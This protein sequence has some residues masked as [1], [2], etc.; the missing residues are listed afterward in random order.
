MPSVYSS[1]AF[2]AY[3]LFAANTNVGKTIFSTGL[4]RAA[5]L[6]ANNH[7]VF[8]LKPVQTGYPTDSDE[9]HVKTYNSSSIYT[10][11]EYTYPDPV[12][13]HIA[14][15]LPPSDRQVMDKT[16]QHILNCV[17]QSKDKAGAYFF[18]ETAGGIHSP[19][20]SGTSQ[21]DFYRPL[22]MPTVL[23]G[24]SNLGGIS[25]TLTSYE[26]LH[27]RG[28]DVPS[29]LLFN[30]D[31]YKNHEL[32]AT[33]LGQSNVPVQVACVPAP[34]A[35]HEDPMKDQEA[36]QRY[37]AE[38]DEYLV[39]VMAY[40]DKQHQDR[41]DRLD[42]MADKARDKFWWPFTQHNLVKKVTVMDSAHQD[43]FVTYDKETQTQNDMFDSCASWW[44]QGL[45]HANPQLTLAAAHAA[46]R[47]GHVMFPESCN[48]PALALAESVLDKD[49]W[50]QR[51]FFSDNGST[52]M[53]VA[54]KMA[55]GSAGKR[56]GWHQQERKPI[57][58]LGLD[59]SYHGDTIGTMDACS[60]NVY[61]D[62]VDWYQPRGTWLEP[63]TVHVSQG[64]AFVHVPA[65]VS[66]QSERIDYDS[67]SSVYS[68]DQLGNQR[69]TA[70]ADIYQRHIREQLIKLRGRNVGAVLME[71]LLMGAGGMIFVDPLF[72]RVMVDTVRQEAKDLLGYQVQPNHEQTDGWQGIPIVFDEVFAGW[73]RLG[74]RSASD[75]LGVK[76]DI[77]AYAKTLTGGLLPLALTV[78]KESIFNTFLSDNKPDCL[79]HGHS[80]TAHPMGS[81]VAK[82][83]ID[84][85]ESLAS[86]SGPWETNYRQPW[87]KHDGGNMWSM[88]NWETVQELSHLPNVESVMSLGSV[89]AV[90]L[91]D[92]QTKGYGS[93][94][95]ASVIQKLRQGRFLDNTGVNVNLFAR[96]LGNVVY[97]MTSQIT[98]P[99]DVGLC[100]RMLLSA[101]KN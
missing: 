89:L 39:P 29:V 25:T 40:L 3:Q 52:A 86:P 47:Y 48:E 58:I 53:E 33:R 43:R 14:T 50:A 18:L 101:L 60:P 62:Q 68:V 97:L 67:L 82:T 92:D 19:V 31:R 37:Y 93:G 2:Q 12:S 73:Y 27:L 96:P 76:P 91:K 65:S 6:S 23:V 42:T 4:C 49:T 35:P 20:M 99:D 88:W 95:S 78:T 46:G 51:V 17:Q 11:T 64:K 66:G 15:T 41:F 57:D 32:M 56:Y 87:K 5:A 26:S 74:R 94:V 16:K 22:R 59:G 79:L 77:A 71:P 24:D 98:T 90:S 38:L 45:G 84:I 10:H 83:T 72:Q 75:H 9:R 54:L 36:M 8:Y 61:N 30:N 81:N 28:Y 44:T 100:E 85:L 21:V 70:L 63:P 34:P 69:D 1:R 55:M 7:N 80:Y 13:P